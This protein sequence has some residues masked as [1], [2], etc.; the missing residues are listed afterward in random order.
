LVKAN[1]PVF[2]LSKK[3][4]SNHSLLL[5]QSELAKPLKLHSPLI[6]LDF[7]FIGIRH[8]NT[9]IFLENTFFDA[10]F[11]VPQKTPSWGIFWLNSFF[12]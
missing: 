9:V 10:R 11:L 8:K 1:F 2:F 12:N 4:G 7:F 6:S 5:G 3:K